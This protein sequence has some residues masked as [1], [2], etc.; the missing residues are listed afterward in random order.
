MNHPNPQKPRLAIHRGFT[1]TELLV[2]IQIIV[3][4]AALSLVSVRRIRDMA[5]KTTAIPS[6]SQPQIANASYATDH[7]R[8][9]V[10]YLVHDENGN[11][12]G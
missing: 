8:N 3:V 7:N 10:P 12:A 1:L 2:V 9:Y 11:R 6:F 5:D 4:I